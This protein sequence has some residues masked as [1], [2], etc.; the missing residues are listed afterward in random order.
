[1][2]STSL[3][4]QSQKIKPKTNWKKT[5]RVRAWTLAKIPLVFLV[6]PKVLELTK[7]RCEVMIP[8]NYVTRNHFKSMYFGA[9]CMGADLAGG[10]FA[11]EVIESSGKKVS[12]IF[13]DFKAEFL[14]RP[15]KDVHFICEEGE[16]IKKAIQ[17]TI[18]TKKRV[19]STIAIWATT[20]KITGDE[21]V[22]KFLLTIS[23]KAA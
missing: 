2:A 8:L 18:Q 3:S 17:E 20:P 23:V 11:I 13:K 1:M 12:F 19:N 22:A 10:I 4:K 9:L 21:P 5:L 7:N 15:E 6:R 16:K 14:K